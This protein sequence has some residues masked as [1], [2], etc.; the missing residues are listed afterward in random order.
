MKRREKREKNGEVGRVSDQVLETLE[1]EECS[2]TKHSNRN[3]K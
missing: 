3:H 1:Q 2:K